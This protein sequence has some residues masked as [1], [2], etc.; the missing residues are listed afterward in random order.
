MSVFDA[1]A[2]EGVEGSARRPAATSAQPTTSTHA[3]PGQ[4]SPAA[5]AGTSYGVEFG[6]PTPDVRE[7]LYAMVDRVRV[8]ELDRAAEALS[9]YL[10]PASKRTL[11]A[12]LGAGRGGRDAVD[13]TAASYSPEVPS[14]AVHHEKPYPRGRVCPPLANVA[15][16]RLRGSLP[17][18]SR[19]V[20][21]SRSTTHGDSSPHAVHRPMISCTC[22]STAV[23][24]DSI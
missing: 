22:S 5:T 6:L 18:L 7:D 19:T 4:L 12:S 21:A 23:C 16:G 15:P 2:L 17:Y 8:E 14:V 9:P 3:A 10:D 13:G 1:A 11:P 24:A 20:V